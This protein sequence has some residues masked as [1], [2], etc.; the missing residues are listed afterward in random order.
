[1][2][3]EEYRIAAFEAIDS[4]GH[5]CIRMETFPAAGRD[6]PEF[7]AQKGAGSD[8]VVLLLGTLY[9]T[10]IANR[11]I[12]YTEDEFNTAIALKKPILVFEPAP[13]AN[14]NLKAA[15][16]AIEENGLTYEIQRERQKA[17]GRRARQG[18]WPRPFKD[19]A[20]LKFQVGHSLSA[21][22]SP[23]KSASYGGERLPYLCNRTRQIEEFAESFRTGLGGAAHVYVVHGD[24]REQ[25]RQ[26][27]DRLVCRH[28]TY[29]KRASP[30]AL[31]GP[32]P[33][34]AAIEWP[35]ERD[36]D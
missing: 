11:E 13:A 27:V 26:C 33:N 22:A 15:L 6:I 28:V 9:G 4:Y 14:T 3:L 18:R 20:D 19:V 36:A 30:A 12:S 23:A 16:E 34:R 2:E 8:V 32:P 21:L 10:P 25:H 35:L 7:C 1:I 17:F 29:P 24:E 31:I 5:R